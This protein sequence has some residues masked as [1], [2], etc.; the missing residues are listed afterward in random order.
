MDATTGVPPS[1]ARTT[2]RHIESD[3]M[4][5]PPGL[6]TRSTIARARWSAAAA[7]SAAVMVSDPM[8]PEAT[9]AT[10]DRAGRIDEGD[11]IL[12][13]VR[14]RAR[15]L[16]EHACALVAGE[17][18]QIGA[19]ADLLP[20]LRVHLVPV[21]ERV[22][23]AG[24]QRLVGQERA[25]VNQRPGVGRRDF[26]ALP[27]RLGDLL[28]DRG[29]EPLHGFPG[30]PGEAVLGQPFG[31]A[32]VLVPPADL[33]VNA[34]LV[35]RA[36]IEPV[37]HADAG[38]P[39]VTGG[40][41]VNAVEGGRQ[42]IRHVA[43]RE[44]A[45]C[46]RPG[47]GE[48]AGPAEFLNG[49][50]QFLD[51]GE[52]DSPAADL[53]DQGPDPVVG[54]RPAEPVEHVSEP[55]PAPRQYRGNGI[56]RWLLRDSLG[57]VQFQ[58]QRSR[59]ALAQPGDPVWDQRIHH[60]SQLTARGMPAVRWRRQRWACH[61]GPGGLRYRRSGWPETMGM[62]GPSAT[63]VTGIGACT[64]PLACW[65]TRA[66]RRGSGACCWSAGPAGPSMGE[67]GDRPAVRGTATSPRPRRPCARPPR[68]AVSPRARYA[69]RAYCAMITV[70][71]PTRPWSRAR[72]RCSRCWPRAGRPPRSAGYRWAASIRC[73]CIPG[74]RRPGQSS[75]TL[76]NRS[77]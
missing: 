4:Y 64:A 57:Q 65:L 5:E 27:D 13:R 47:D 35:Q 49:G 46:L 75:G 20:D 21:A 66:T 68:S 33:I 53:H 6:L 56:G 73:R 71:G 34:Q 54:A 44:V 37:L 29:G 8:E 17:V 10:A 42:V 72:R 41:Q 45:E 62:A 74:S 59:P 25:A 76:P 55:G 50:A 15:A 39:D 26:E 61:R 67:P 51:P 14:Q 1:R 28:D 63:L 31:G 58:D 70:A 12:A 2:S 32:L 3:A 43:G 77:R 11:D 38:Q 30:G 22:D 23:Q 24:V 7:R 52:P 19:R 48:L 18:E 16:R 36:A 9:A 69:S 40:L 60:A